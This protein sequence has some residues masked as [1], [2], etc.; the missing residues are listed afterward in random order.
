MRV[1]IVDL[2]KTNAKVALVDTDRAEEIAVRSTPVSPRADGPYPHLDVG[3]LRAAIV[4][5]LAGLAREGPIDAIGV[6]AHGAT[7]ALLDGAGE[8]ALPVLDY[9]HDGPDELADEYDAARPAFAESG[10]P[11]LPG[12]LNVGAQLLWQE[13][14]FADAFA[15]VRSIVTWP[16]YWAHLLCGV[17]C[18]ELSSLG[19]HTDLLDVR[20]M[21][22]SS[23]AVARGWD[24]RLAPTRRPGKRLGPVRADV[25]RATGLS[26]GTPVHVGIHDSNASLVP[27]LLGAERPLSVVSSG[28]W[29]IAM[30]LGGRAVELDPVR[31][32]LVNVDA[33]GDA[34]PSA[35]F[36][37]GRER[38]LLSR[39]GAGRSGTGGA[40]ASRAEEGGAERAPS[41]MRR[42]LE[43]GAFVLPG[44]VAGCGPWP[45]RE[46]PEWSVDEATLDDDEHAAAIG[47]ALG[48]VAATCLELAGADGPTVIEGP[49]AADPAATA[50]LRAA[51][52]REVRAGGGATGTAVGTGMTIAVPADAGGAAPRP[53]AESGM[54]VEALERYARRWR[55]AI[56]DGTGRA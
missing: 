33:F 24:R 29:T 11:R 14:R 56:G 7:V 40:D 44:A 1:A 28:T 43:R 38:E 50:M 21:C 52:G 5:A 4:D 32:T 16:Q 53:V 27:H 10:S 34:V 22:P 13:R 12:G 42:V 18:S 15:R 25:A 19:A 39:S 23:L 47:L 54:P 51:T 8:L 9:E 37:G 36:M 45:G 30:A 48:L 20:S 41:A 6:C 35:R 3:A 26:P 55:E 46:T 49:M 17:A 2:G 31:D